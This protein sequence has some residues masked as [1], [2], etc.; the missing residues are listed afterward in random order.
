[1]IDVS[2]VSGKKAGSPAPSGNG[3]MVLMRNEVDGHQVHLQDYNHVDG[4][5]G[6]G[7]YVLRTVPHGV[8]T[9]YDVLLPI[10]RTVPSYVGTGTDRTVVHGTKYNISETSHPNLDGALSITAGA[11]SPMID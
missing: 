3:T 2:D 11:V 9:R 8:S 4:G 7:G 5:H 10:Y 6:R 1:M